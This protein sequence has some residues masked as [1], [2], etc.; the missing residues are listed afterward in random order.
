ME[1]EAVCPSWEEPPS[2]TLKFSPMLMI[3]FTWVLCCHS[4]LQ[5]KCPLWLVGGWKPS[6]QFISFL[7]VIA[8]TLTTIQILCFFS[9]LL[10]RIPIPCRMQTRLWQ[11]AIPQTPDL[12]WLLAPAS[13]AMFGLWHW[14]TNF[15]AVEVIHPQYHQM[16]KQDGKSCREQIQKGDIWEAEQTGRRWTASSCF[17]FQETYGVTSFV[18]KEHTGIYATCMN[19]CMCAHVCIYLKSICFN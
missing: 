6:W 12:K 17:G 15:Q 11:F 3:K 10:K 13:W 9:E 19:R 16:E 4:I 18:S 14:V 1:V 2:L 7:N 5:R 8:Q